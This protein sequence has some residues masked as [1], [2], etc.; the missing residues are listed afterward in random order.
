LLAWNQLGRSG[1]G[2]RCF[3]EIAIICFTSGNYAYVFPACHS[4]P[5]S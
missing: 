1:L 5:F 4:F 3:C 2:G